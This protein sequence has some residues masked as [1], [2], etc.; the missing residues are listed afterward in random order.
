M[1]FAVAGSILLLILFGYGISFDVEHIPFAA[2]D[3]DRTIES[4]R[5]VEAFEGTSWFTARPPIERDD[6]VDRRLKSGELRLVVV[7]PPGFGHDLLVGARPEVAFHVDGANTFRAE[8]VK[9]YVQGVVLGWVT[10]VATDTY[11]P[12]V[13]LGLP[14]DLRPRWAY[15]QSFQSLA[16][17]TPGVVMLLLMLI[18]SGMTAVGVV[19]EREIGSYANLQASPAGVTEFLVGKQLPYVAVGIVSF[20]TLAATAV[21]GFGVPLRG[22]PFALLLGATLY[23]FAA[24]GFGLLV[25]TLVR[26]QLA[27]MFACAI[28]TVVPAVNFSGFLNP[29][30]SLGGAAR[31]VGLLFPTSWFQTISLGTFAKGLDAFDL[32]KENLVLLAFAV[33]FVGAACLLLDKQDR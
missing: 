30:S 18:P 7:I 33:A 14:I 16:A 1:A 10:R 23:V 8:T 32:W 27:A 20:L 15:N 11:G 24:T 9:G 25:S 5:F 26:S 19:R 3:R 28:L 4:R 22:S 29:V 2:W 21:F 6:D 12:G 17:I 31:W 13:S